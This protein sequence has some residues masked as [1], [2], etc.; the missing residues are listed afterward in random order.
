MRHRSTRSLWRPRHARDD[1]R[2]GAG[3][4][5]SSVQRNA[6]VA[7]GASNQTHATTEE[8]CVPTISARD[9]FTFASLLSCGWS[10][11]P[12]STSSRLR[13]LAPPFRRESRGTGLAAHAGTLSVG[14][15]ICPGWR[16]VGFLDLS[17]G[18]LGDVDGA[19]D[20]VGWSPLALRSFRHLGSLPHS[21][22]KIDKS[23]TTTLP[24]S[25]M[26]DIVFPFRKMSTKPD[27][28]QLADGADSGCPSA[29]VELRDDAADSSAAT[30]RQE[31]HN[32]ARPG[33]ARLAPGWD[34][35]RWVRCIDNRSRRVGRG[36]HPLAHGLSGRVG[37]ARSRQIV[38]YANA[39]VPEL[40][41]RFVRAFVEP[42]R[43]TQ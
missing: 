19:G 32:S 40:A 4:I 26:V 22:V 11:T 43:D 27:H 3:T 39:I 38:G 23:Q 21:G 20:R 36:V 7:A 35:A 17:G 16:L 13:Y 42:V 12:P 14:L 41:A 28:G 9:T 25:V 30:A 33:A 1:R 34:D 6:P 5:E 24:M 37:A 8:R 15:R 29:L 31:L 18:D 10:R 2:P